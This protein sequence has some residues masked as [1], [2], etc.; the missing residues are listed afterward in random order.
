[1]PP[2]R[3]ETTTAEARNGHNSRHGDMPAA[4]ITMISE[5][6]LSL[7]RVWAAAMTSAIGASIMTRSG[8]IRP[9]MPTKTNSVCR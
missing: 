7:L 6:V 5:S 4:F 1:M 9:V 8:M 2:T 3:I